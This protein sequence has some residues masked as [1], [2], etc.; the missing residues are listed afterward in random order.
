[1]ILGL[2][3]T[4]NL[5]DNNTEYRKRARANPAP[6]LKYTSVKYKYNRFSWIISTIGA[7]SIL[8]LLH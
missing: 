6:I 7:E 3:K 2:F 4:L 1:M 5:F 8:P